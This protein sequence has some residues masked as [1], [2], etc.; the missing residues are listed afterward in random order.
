MTW[1]D[2]ATDFPRRRASTSCSKRRR[3]RHRT[4][5]AVVFEAQRLTYREL[6]ARAN[7]LAH[8]L[9]S[10]ASGRRCWSASASSGRSRWWSACSASSR[11][12][13]PTCRSIRSIPGSGSPS[14]SK[15]PAAWLVTDSGSRCVCSCPAHEVV[16]LD[17]DAEIIAR[18]PATN[19]VSTTQAG[20]FAYVIYTSGSTG[21][22]KGVAVP[23]GALSNYLQRTTDAY[24]SPNG[25]GAAA[26]L[27]PFDGV[28]SPLFTPWLAG[29]QLTLPRGEFVS[30]TSSGMRNKPF[31]PR[32]L[33]DPAQLPSGA[34]AAVR[35][36]ALAVGQPHPRRRSAHASSCRAVA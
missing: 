29:E 6:N 31:G 16:R 2:T 20:D 18:A 17:T 35:R 7:Q 23:H 8:H 15:I 33:T 28:T 9:R 19:P 36:L 25:L 32:L 27:A 4:P 24:F 34:G 30:R 14:C 22:P 3:R 1:N 10:G 11:R 5:S 13:A 21:K 12:A 26:T